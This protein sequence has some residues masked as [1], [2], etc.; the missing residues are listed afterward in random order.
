MY[1]DYSISLLTSQENVLT[2]KAELL[3]LLVII[4]YGFHAVQLV[5][6]YRNLR[7]LELRGKMF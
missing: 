1:F 6:H 7:I 4:E 2:L 3:C 5:S